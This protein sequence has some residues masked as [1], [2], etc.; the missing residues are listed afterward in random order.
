MKKKILEELE[1]EKNKREIL[2]RTQSLNRENNRNQ[3]QG[4]REMMRDNTFQGDTFH[5]EAKKY[6]WEY[7]LENYRKSKAMDK[8]HTLGAICGIVA[9]FMTLLINWDVLIQ[10]IK[11]LL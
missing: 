4:E 10:F 2:K 11:K 6:A 1:F 8:F 3:G 5:G 7:E 9:L